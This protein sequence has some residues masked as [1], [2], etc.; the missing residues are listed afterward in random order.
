MDLASVVQEFSGCRHL[1][2]AVY[3]CGRCLPWLKAMERG[4]QE[5]YRAI[6][7]MAEVKAGNP[8]VTVR[9]FVE[10]IRS[11][12]LKIVPDP[13]DDRVRLAQAAE[14][15]VKSRCQCEKGMGA[16]CIEGCVC[17]HHDIARYLLEETD[18]RPNAVE[19]A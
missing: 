4:K 9:N 13:E 1:T 14:K 6:L 7:A 12:V 19:K 15:F 17:P 18:D 3:T 5:G 11:L 2:G 10:T 8:G 16:S